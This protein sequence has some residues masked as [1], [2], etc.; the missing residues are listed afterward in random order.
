MP[1]PSDNSYFAHFT[2]KPNNVWAIFSG[3]APII[4]TK[5]TPRA[6]ARG[7]LSPHRPGRRRIRYREAFRADPSQNNRFVQKITSAV[8]ISLTEPSTSPHSGTWRSGALPRSQGHGLAAHCPAV[9]HM[10]EVQSWAERRAAPTK[11]D[12]AE[13]HTSPQS[14]T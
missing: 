4:R 8:P 3:P 14:G 6:W 9:R 1:S 5:K 13:R 12:M 11:R 7:P 2:T 10:A